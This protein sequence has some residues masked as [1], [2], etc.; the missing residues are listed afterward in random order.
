M[1]YDVGRGLL[2]NWIICLKEILL[3]DLSN[4]K[5]LA[6]CFVRYVL[7]GK[8]EYVLSTSTSMN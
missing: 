4:I 3:K 5:H 1:W 8:C 6:H 7:L 2:I